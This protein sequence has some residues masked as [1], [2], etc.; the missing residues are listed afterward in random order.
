M[1]FEDFKTKWLFTMKSPLVVFIL[2]AGLIHFLFF[3]FVKIKTMNDLVYEVPHPKELSMTIR[4][5]PIKDG[6]ASLDWVAL[7]TPAILSEKATES[8]QAPS[9]A[10]MREDI[11][12]TVS[13][14]RKTPT[15]SLSERE[16][17]VSK[18]SDL[19]QWSRRQLM[20]REKTSPIPLPVETP[21]MVSGTVVQFTGDL[22]NRKVI[23]EVKFPQPSTTIALKRTVLRFS[24]NERGFVENIFMEESS[25]A[26]DVDKQAQTLLQ[27]WRFEP[28]TAQKSLVWGKAIVFWDIQQAT[29]A[30]GAR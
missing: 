10:S 4:P 29:P 24:L 16:L 13:Y 6:V 15:V 8:L 14:L 17:E 19:A 30:A 20:R 11:K 1:P 5:A 23:K 18:N 9:M 7:K 27:Q 25:G 3:Y 28:D 22:K 21:P 2:G 26:A 12:S